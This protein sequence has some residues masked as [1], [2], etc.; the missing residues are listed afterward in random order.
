MSESDEYGDKL[1]VSRSLIDGDWDWPIHGL[2]HAPEAGTS[3]WYIWTG[4]FNEAGDFF[5]PLHAAH[6]VQRAPG[7]AKF[8]TLPPGSR[9]L[10]APD[11]EDIWSD[12]TL[13]D[14]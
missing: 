6:L 1:G 8:L 12:E 10:I 11:H 3:G 13:L 4:E 2:R 9:F 7:V 14:I 5:Q